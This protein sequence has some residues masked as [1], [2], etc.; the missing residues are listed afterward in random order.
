MK[1]SGLRFRGMFNIEHIRD[2]K[3]IG[4]YDAKNGVVDEGLNKILDVM[5]HATT[6]LGTWYL[7]L[8][9][10]AGFTAVAAADTMA[11]HAGWAEN[12]DY[13]EA[14]RIEWAEGA[15]SGKSI[16]NATPETFNIDA[17]AVIRGCF[18]VSNNTKG[19]STGTLWATALFAAA[20]NVNNGDQLKVTYTINAATS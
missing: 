4:R 12:E 1:E 13:S 10:N 19:G 7:G 9:D 17:T 6:Q 15:A 8:I 14:T 16:T 5:F 11:S 20:V 18:I 2:G 3:I